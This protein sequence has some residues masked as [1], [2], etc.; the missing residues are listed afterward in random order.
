[1]RLINASLGVYICLA[2]AFAASPELTIE[3]KDY[4][5]FPITGAVAGTSNSTSLLA[6]IN[7]M[8][9]E[10]GGSKKR[11][12]VNDINGPLYILDK[13]T[14]KLTTYLNFNGLEGQTGLFRRLTI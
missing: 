2:C 5:T 6:R 10:P 14:K 11:F 9:E 8:R 3:I 13:E 12:F 7:F 1:M 4:A